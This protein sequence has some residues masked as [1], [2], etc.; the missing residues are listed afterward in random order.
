MTTEQT[1]K[2]GRGRP[3]KV[4]VNEQDISAMKSRISHLANSLAESNKHKRQWETKC[5]ELWAKN[6]EARSL[7]SKLEQVIKDLDEK[8]KSQE[9]EIDNQERAYRRLSNIVKSL[10]ESLYYSSEAL[11]N[12]AGGF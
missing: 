8:V 5:D 2:K 4:K 1:P 9:G 6:D 7:I 12:I 3:A 10:T 11:N